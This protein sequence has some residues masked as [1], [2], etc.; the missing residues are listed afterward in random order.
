[1]ILF[2]SLCSIFAI[3]FYIPYEGLMPSL[4]KNARKKRF[5]FPLRQL[6]ESFP[7][8]TRKL[9]AILSLKERQI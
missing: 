7:L 9:Q 2:Q 1:M 4:V 3:L 8:N 6:M 5:F